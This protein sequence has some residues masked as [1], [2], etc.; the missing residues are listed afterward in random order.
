MPKNPCRKGKTRTRR[1]P[2]V[3]YYTRSTLSDMI[4]KLK[5]TLLHKDKLWKCCYWCKVVVFLVTKR[6][7]LCQCWHLGRDISTHTLLHRFFMAHPTI[8][9]LS[10]VPICVL[11]KLHG[12]CKTSSCSQFVSYT[13]YVTHLVQGSEDS[14]W[15]DST[16][17]H[18]YP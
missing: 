10:A 16:V 4:I 1:K 6:M 13:N 7:F 2:F 18:I 14:W 8:I 11:K 15:V 12:H 17:S 9:L 3:R 5:D